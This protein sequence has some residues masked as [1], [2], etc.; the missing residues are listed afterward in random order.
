MN[1][2]HPFDHPVGGGQQPT[3][4]PTPSTT[5][6]ST[7]PLAEPLD[8]MP[9]PAIPWPAREIPQVPEFPRPWPP[10][11]PCRVNLA[12]GCYALTIQP[13]GFVT[14]QGTMRVERGA[15]A[16]TVSGDLYRF[17]NLPTP[18]PIPTLP[19]VPQLPGITDADWAE[20]TTR[21]AAALASIGTRFPFR[22]RI[23]IYP[24]GKY[25]SYLKVT[26]IQQL[27]PVPRLPC[28]LTLTVEEYVYTQ[29]PTGSFNGSFPST[30]TRTVQLVLHEV[31]SP[32]PFGP[33]FEGTIFEGGT[34]KGSV[35][36]TWVSTSY[37]RATVEVDVVQ[38]AVAP[39]PVAASSGSGG[40]DIRSVFASAGWDVMVE[41][42]Q[43][44]IPVP[45]AVTATNC[46]SSADLHSLMQ[47]VRK[48]TTDLDQEWRIHLICV[49]A[50]LGCGRGV[51]YDQIG[52]PREGVASFS[53]DGYPSGE[54]AFFGTAANQQQRNVPRAFL[55]SACHEVGH[56][57][58][59][60]H[61]EQEGGADNSIMTTTPSVANVL[62]GPPGVFPDDISL[63]F[64]NHVR[65][66]LIH[67]PDP[68]LRPGGMTFGSGHSSSVP[69]ADRLYFA[70]DELELDLHVAADHIELGEPLRLSW[71]LTNRTDV[72]IPVPSDIGVEAQ[73]AFVRVTNPHGVQRTMRSFV[74][75]TDGVSLDPLAPGDQLSAE[76]RVFW[77]SD[78]FAFDSPGRY[79]V[80]V[81]VIWAQGPTPV[82]TKTSTE[83]WV[84]YPHSDSDNEAAALLLHPVV[85]KYVGLGGAPHLTEAVERLSQAARLP[86]AGD[87]PGAR[88]LRGYDGLL[89]APKA[90]R[91]APAKAKKA[92]AKARK[93]PS[94]S[95]AK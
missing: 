72:A 43:T 67:W 48:S 32:P 29:P 49:P 83:V 9:P 37:R 20:A 61:Q 6:G 55:R 39:Q 2:E 44:N 33:K 86:A 62:G 94:R 69:S 60:I 59:Q 7:V 51:M 47:N 81:D 31:P 89:P 84:N 27:R 70:A 77:D 76:T 92:P 41:Y 14:Y 90:A 24:R 26:G 87:K 65:H 40:E 53:D 74:I 64:N 16:A 4:L 3:Q 21:S 85:G 38:G 46:W 19:Q 54:S 8:L 36:M 17:L 34:A 15:T 10:S 80:E 52:V 78:G 79:Q 22:R 13:S 56:G 35:T 28:T 23:P 30:A 50:Q 75:C 58:N 18:L 12:Q 73:H 5:A 71:T 68:V 11:L 82:G 42:D 66:H 63:S 1:D 57:F 93:A 25:H 88:A 45:S 91:K 95:R